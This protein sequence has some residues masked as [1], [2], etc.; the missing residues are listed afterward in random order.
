MR[1]GIADI[2]EVVGYLIKVIPQ[3]GRSPIKKEIPEAEEE[4]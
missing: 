3:G 2:P 1:L 4:D